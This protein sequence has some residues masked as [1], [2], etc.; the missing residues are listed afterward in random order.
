M[1]VKKMKNQWLIAILLLIVCLAL[2][3]WLFFSGK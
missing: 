1:S 3:A 2:S